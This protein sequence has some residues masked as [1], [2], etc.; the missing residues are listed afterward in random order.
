[1]KVVGK[2]SALQSYQ[3]S[4]D[5]CSLLDSAASVHVFHSK[6]RFS[7][8][9]RPA[10][11]QGLLCG[12]GIVPIEG[13]GEVALPLKIG[14]RTSI[15][16]LKNVAYIS[17]FPLN[18]VSLAVLED[19]GFI[20][21][22]WSGE[23]RNKKSK[24]IGST[25]RRGK[26]YE[27]GDSTSMGTAL[28]TLN[29][30]KLRPGYVVAEKKIEEN[31][32]LHSFSI[33]TPESS[34]SLSVDKDSLCTYN[35]LHA[36]ASPDIW[37][38][39]MGHISP[40]GL[41]KLGKECLGVKLRG[42]TMSQCPH[43]ALSKI[44]QQ[45]SRRPSANKSTR[46]FHRVFVDW[47]DLEEGWDTYQGDGAI[48]RRA[49]VVICEATGMAITY[50]TQS[51]KEDENLPLL[52]DFVTW[53]ELRYNLE[54]KVIRSD[55]EMNQIKT[56]DWCNNVGIS[57]EPCAPDTHAQNGGAERFGRLIMEKA[58]AMRLSTNLPH[59]L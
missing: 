20:W 16:V 42:K 45:I 6:E 32:S 12:G 33:Q 15:L 10:R 13:W 26:N 34:P 56:R 36:I 19:Q 23:I 59:K 44:S 58:Q 24:I 25:V 22:H 48:V 53:L 30:S 29:T 40:L 49:M 21:H 17:D 37:H 27:I 35:Q 38:C 14:N 52:Q 18:L 47:L 51:A 46:P 39:R 31:C 43:C 1:M 41:Y 57:F 8:F 28:V 7:N 9:K 54:V 3:K 11:R 50:F 55:N 4:S 2:A 5:N